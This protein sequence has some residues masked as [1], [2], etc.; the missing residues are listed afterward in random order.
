MTSP[1]FEQIVRKLDELASFYHR[2]IVVVA[3]VGSSQSN[4]LREVAGR[5]GFRYISA[6][7]ELS[8]GLLEVAQRD[9]PRQAAQ[10]LREIVESGEP[11]GAILDNIELL[12]EVSLKLNPLGYLKEL[13]RYRTV[14]AAWSGKLLDGHLIYAESNHPE[15]RCYPVDGFLA[16][17]HGESN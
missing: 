6:S 15:Y 17:A 10:L 11:Q 4:V 5:A 14:V 8:R 13:A 3:P 12:F 9:R 7:L 16:I 2:L 1:L